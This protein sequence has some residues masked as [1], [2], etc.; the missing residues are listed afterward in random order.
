MKRVLFVDDDAT[1]LA[2]LKLC[3][4]RD[5]TRWEMIF[6]SDSEEALALLAREPVDVVVSD[7]RMPG[8]DGAALLAEVKAMYPDTRRLILS[9]YSEPETTQRGLLVAHVWLPKPCDPAR[10]RAAIEPAPEAT[11]APATPTPTP[12]PER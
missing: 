2:G 5:R 1:I 8:M 7:M 10:L 9:G 3:F 4:R 11:A 6:A 12:S